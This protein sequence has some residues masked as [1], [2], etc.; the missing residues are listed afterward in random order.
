MQ[1]F[2]SGLYLTGERRVKHFL[3]PLTLLLFKSFR[4]GA[5]I[6]RVKT[7]N[8][9]QVLL[10]QR[11]AT[12]GGPERTLTQAAEEC[13]L[14]ERQDALVY[15]PQAEACKRLQ[16]FVDTLLVLRFTLLGLIERTGLASAR[17]LSLKKTRLQGSVKRAV[18][19]YWPD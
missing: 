6:V 13:F 19:R 1:D 4:C 17:S 9:L 7:C 10:F 12:L 16:L 18:V 11:A 14:W 5:K 15:A 8:R 2:L 3:Q